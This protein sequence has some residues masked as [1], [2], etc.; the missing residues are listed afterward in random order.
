MSSQYISLRETAQLL[1]VSEQKVM[2]M[3]QS[4]QL[5][6]Y[7]CHKP[8]PDAWRERLL[9]LTRC[10]Q[11]LQAAFSARALRNLQEQKRY[12]L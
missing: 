7:R 1:S 10:P 9:R 11:G 5:Q 4:G 12:P 8:W 6:A 2:D 3:I